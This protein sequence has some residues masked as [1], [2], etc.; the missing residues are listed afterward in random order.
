MIRPLSLLFPA[1]LAA[2]A[3]A[4]AAP[5]D[6]C[7]DRED[8]IIPAVVDNTVNYA[9]LSTIRDGSAIIVWNAAANR[10]LSDSEQIFIYLHECAHH[11][12]GHLYVP[13]EDR[14][15]ELEADCWAIQL[16][17]DGGMIKGRH[18][19]ELER[20]RRSVR[21]DR[22]HLGGEAHIL[23]L[24]ECME[25]RLSREAWAAALD[26]LLRSAAEDFRPS[27]GRAIDSLAAVPVYESLHG[28]PGTYDCEVVG[29]A[30][31]CLVFASRDPEPAA[32]RY[33]RLVRLLGRW[34]PPGWTWTEREDPERQGRVWLAQDARSGTLLSLARTGAR[35]HFL[36]KRAPA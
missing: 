7:R 19:A 35:V 17:V 8:R 25:A 18:L 5:F 26:T 32:E 24:R 16:M 12:L 36:M 2:P 22:S 20:S 27:R 34:L 28:A 6:A 33:D 13:G 29:A 3:A 15:L 14:R 30:V 1:L 4:Q 10:H 23:S 11:R 31:R 9:A 21:G